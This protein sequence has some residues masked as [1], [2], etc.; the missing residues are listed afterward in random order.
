MWSFVA[1][2][3]NG[4]EKLRSTDL[5]SAPDQIDAEYASPAP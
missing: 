5:D 4:T 3:R 2:Y 1:K